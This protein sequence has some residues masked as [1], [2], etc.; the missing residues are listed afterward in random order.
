MVQVCK[1]KTLNP[2]PVPSGCLQGI[3]I[4]D[5]APRMETQMEENMENGME[6][7]MEAT[8]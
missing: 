6:S 2:E 1:Y 4:Q 7:E 8:I 5:V 3:G